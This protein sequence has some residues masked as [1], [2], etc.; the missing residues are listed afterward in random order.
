MN[1]VYCEDST[2]CAIIIL[3]VLIMGGIVWAVVSLE[4]FL[5]LGYA[6]TYPSLMK[7]QPKQMVR[8]SL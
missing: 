6:Y 8:K 5:S 3:F 1:D 2:L 7:R 4:V